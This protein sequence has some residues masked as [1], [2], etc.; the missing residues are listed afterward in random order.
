MIFD[1]NR[2]WTKLPTS[3][4]MFRGYP[5]IRPSKKLML[6]LSSRD[7]AWPLPPFVLQNKSNTIP[8]LWKLL[9]KSFAWNLERTRHVASKNTLKKWFKWMRHSEVEKIRFGKMIHP[10]DYMLQ[11]MFKCHYQPYQSLIQQI[12]DIN[13]NWKG[14]S[15]DGGLMVRFKEIYVNRWLTTNLNSILWVVGR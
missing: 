14:K 8:G 7:I 15:V 12:F 13:I 9:V 11:L 3:S 6:F 5:F 1:V 4:K 2:G 10:C